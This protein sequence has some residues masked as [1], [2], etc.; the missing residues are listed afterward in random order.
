MST[1]C[2]SCKQ[3]VRA[4]QQ[5]LRCDGCLRWKHR[6]CGTGGCQSHY[7]RRDAAKNDTSI[8]WRCSTCDFAEPIPLAE[9]TPVNFESTVSDPPSVLLF[10]ISEE[11]IPTGFLKADICG[12]SKRHLVF[13]TNQQLQQLVQAKNWYVDGTFKLCQ[14]FSQLF[15][16]NALFETKLELSPPQRLHQ[17]RNVEKRREKEEKRG[18]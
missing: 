10:E 17:W 14:P 7:R 12:R 4:R 18:K 11:N 9:S 8:D 16:I 5:G 6:K 13:T 1:K 3:P 15:T 2:I